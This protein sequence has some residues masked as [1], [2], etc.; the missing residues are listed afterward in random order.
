MRRVSAMPL[1]SHLHPIPPR[2]IPRHER[3]YYLELLRRAGLLEDFPAVEAI[4][5]EGGAAA[6]GVRIESL[7]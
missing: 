7:I 2:D 1:A 5:L 4:R 3:Y 6:G